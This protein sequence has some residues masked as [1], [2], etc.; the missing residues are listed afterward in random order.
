MPLIRFLVILSLKDNALFVPGDDVDL[1]ALGDLDVRPQQR[2]IAFHV[3]AFEDLG[4][5]GWAFGKILRWG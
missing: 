5:L 1:Q 3:R 4:A 2:D